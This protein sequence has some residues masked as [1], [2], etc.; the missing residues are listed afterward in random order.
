MYIN[1]KNKKHI[2]IETFFEIQYRKP[3]QFTQVFLNIYKTR[4]I[5]LH[6]FSYYMN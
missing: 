6:V 3:L 2:N 1:T 4:I 5:F